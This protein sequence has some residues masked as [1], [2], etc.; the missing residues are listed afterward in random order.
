MSLCDNITDEPY[1]QHAKSLSSI[2]LPSSLRLNFTPQ[3]HPTKLASWGGRPG[4]ASSSAPSSGQKTPLLARGKERPFLISVKSARKF[5]DKKILD[6]LLTIMSDIAD[7][8][9][10]FL[11]IA[12]GLV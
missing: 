10:K 1:G 4:Y 11:D 3:S 7:E 12:R 2:F 5:D 8:V 9:K 6:R